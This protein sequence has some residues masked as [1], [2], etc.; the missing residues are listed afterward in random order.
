MMDGHRLNENIYD[1]A[2][3]GTEFPLDLDLIDHIEIVRGPSSSLYG[4]NAIFGIINVITRRPGSGNAKLAVSGE[5]SSFLG[6]AGAIT[7]TFQKGLGRLCFPAACTVAPGS[8][9]SIFLNLPLK[10]VASPTTSMGTA[11]RMP[12]PTWNSE[13]FASKV[14]T[15]RE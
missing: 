14:C 8:Q 11:P 1:S 9:S 4:T 2:L 7:S 10:M 13:T 12:L 3:I 5:Q 6:R 15:E